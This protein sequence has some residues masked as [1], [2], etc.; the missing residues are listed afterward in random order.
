MGSFN[1]DVETLKDPTTEGSEFEWKD[2]LCRLHSR[3]YRAEEKTI[4]QRKAYQRGASVKK[5]EHRAI[6]TSACLIYANS[7]STFGANVGQ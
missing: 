7:N 1:R 3:A 5:M 2:L 4:R 6:T